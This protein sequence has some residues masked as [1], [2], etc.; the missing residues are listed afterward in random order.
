MSFSTLRQ[1]VARRKAD[2]PSDREKLD[3]ALKLNE[4]LA[5]V[6]Y[7]K[8]K[9]RLFWDQSG[10]QV[11]QSRLEDWCAQADL[12]GIRVLYTMDRTLRT[13]RA[14]LLASYD[15]PISTG[16]LEGTNNKIK[17]LQHTAYGYRNREYFRLRILTLHHTKNRLTG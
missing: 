14:G 8:E 16:P 13:H 2:Q 3:A 11:A 10:R 9:L 6:Y 5:T 12:S 15:H 1:R 7:L 17:L 4:P